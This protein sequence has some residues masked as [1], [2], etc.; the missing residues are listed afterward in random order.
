M[1]RKK[2]GKGE[3]TEGLISFSRERVSSFSLGF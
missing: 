3:M 2:K 1:G